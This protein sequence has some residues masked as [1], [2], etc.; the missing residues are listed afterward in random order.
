MKR[1]AIPSK[2]QEPL[3]SENMAIVLCARMKAQG[4]ISWD[5]V[6]S[7]HAGHVWNDSLS[8]LSSVSAVKVMDAQVQSAEMWFKIYLHSC[9][10]FG[11][12]HV[13]H[14]KDSNHDFLNLSAFLFFPVCV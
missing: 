5:H 3:R 13:Y 10:L 12:L 11:G 6:V 2:K 7:N 9:F 14:F 4:I 8:S 1:I